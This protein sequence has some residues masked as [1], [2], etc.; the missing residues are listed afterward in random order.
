MNGKI[1]RV[2]SAVILLTIG[3]MGGYLL[4]S[5]SHTEGAYYSYY[6][7][8]QSNW[9][10]I[11]A[12]TE[13]DYQ[14]TFCYGDFDNDGIKE[15]VGSYSHSAVGIFIHEKTENGWNREILY[16]RFDPSLTH[17]KGMDGGWP[18]KGLVSGDF[19]GDGFDEI[20]SM[21]DAINYPP[22]H[23][24]GSDTIPF[25]GCI[26]IDWVDGE[27]FVANPLV[28]GKWGEDIS[29]NK[30]AIMIVTPLS[31]SFRGGSYNSSLMD[32]LVTTLH[33]TSNGQDGR[34]FILE[35]PDST[36]SSVDYRYISE[37]QIDT[38]LSFP[39][40]AFY[41]KHLYIATPSGDMEMVFSPSEWCRYA[42]S[43]YPSANVWD[44][45]NDGLLDLVV[46]VGYMDSDSV[47]L[48]SIIHVYHRLPA[49]LN[50]K[51]RFKEVYRK[52]LRGVYLYGPRLANLN[53]DPS[54]GK[55]SW[56]FWC[57]VDSQMRRFGVNG[58]ATLQW[59][60]DKWVLLGTHASD[61]FDAKIRY[62]GAYSFPAVIDA[63]NDGYDDVVIYCVR[64]TIKRPDGT[65]FDIG[66]LVLF[67]NVAGKIR[68]YQELFSLDESVTLWV[69]DSFNWDVHVDDFDDDGNLEVG[70][71]LCRP[72]PYWDGN[73]VYQVY[74][75]KVSW[76]LSSQ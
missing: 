8:P 47:I 28:W 26:Y 64:G 25:P 70:C 38:N 35:Q 42:V 50:H 30:A 19:D 56:I 7:S 11:G 51:Y 20:I 74:Y 13:D 43:A 61:R 6:N 52:E 45:D 33:D 67:R 60:N 55:E 3:T 4:G 53:G 49:S 65:Y 41:V 5:I 18:V 22:V 23:G 66:D 2:I 68:S 54:D 73:G 48:G 21:A 76:P 17:T 57:R 62:D 9:T 37:N 44:Y 34:V 36:F 10:S 15:L 63:D 29:S 24:N 69:N 14:Q 71:S 59:V 39:N 32:F 12:G 31:S 58:V 72:E 1:V 46:S 27:G 40:E 16:P 75:S